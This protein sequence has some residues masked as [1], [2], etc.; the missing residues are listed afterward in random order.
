MGITFTAF[1]IIDQTWGSVL[2][3]SFINSLAFFLLL[4]V[5]YVDYKD[6]DGESFEISYQPLHIIYGKCTFKYEDISR[7][8]IY[9]NDIIGTQDV[10]CGDFRDIQM[11]IGKYKK[12]KDHIYIY[13]GVV[14]CI[15]CCN[16]NKCPKCCNCRP[17]DPTNPTANGKVLQIEFKKNGTKMQ[18]L[19]WT[20]NGCCCQRNVKFN[21]IILEYYDFVRFQM[22]LQNSKDITIE[23]S[24]D[25][26]VNG[27]QQNA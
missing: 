11:G 17:Y 22:F 16:E 15:S 20:T 3:L 5:C 12:E 6:V 18:V 2:L 23:G 14:G 26:T 1:S 9:R 24:V 27:N 21:A 19:P 10:L 25:L 8:K 7:I 4:N 13:Q